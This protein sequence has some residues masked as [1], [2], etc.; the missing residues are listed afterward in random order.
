MRKKQ[1]QIV[2]QRKGRVELERLLADGNIA[3]K[4][5]KRARIVLMSADGHGVMAI[6][7]EAQVSK[8]T[9]WR[10]Q[11]YFVEAGVEGLAKSRSK[12]PGKKPISA[13]PTPR[14][15]ACGRWPR[16]WAPAM[17]QGAFLMKGLNNVR[18]EFSLTAG[19]QHPR[20]RG[21]DG[22]RP[23]VTG[24]ALLAGPTHVDD[25]R[26]ITAGTLRQNA[27]TSPKGASAICRRS[28]G[29]VSTRFAR[30]SQQHLIIVI[31]VE[32]DPAACRRW[33]L[34]EDHS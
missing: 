6:M 18:A 8:T 17:N 23:G 7:R 34:P 15:A 32:I 16:G 12:P 14:T 13:R 9:V 2:L 10:W 11:E 3:Q 33:S 28:D 21:D 19:A 22:D 1:P 4:I 29:A 31:M 24:G 25:N 5:A 20:R 27:Q 26:G 30:F